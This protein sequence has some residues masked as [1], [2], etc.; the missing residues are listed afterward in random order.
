MTG[1]KQLKMVMARLFAKRKSRPSLFSEAIEAGIK[2][3]VKEM[4]NKNTTDNKVK[5]S[6]KDD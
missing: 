5:H 6:I 4:N 1:L 2:D 3:L